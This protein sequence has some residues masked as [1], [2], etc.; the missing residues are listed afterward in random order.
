MNAKNPKRAEIIA[1]RIIRLMQKA[2]FTP[3]EMLTCLAM[4][5]VKLEQMLSKRT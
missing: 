4:A 2:D 3:E 1:T 5:R